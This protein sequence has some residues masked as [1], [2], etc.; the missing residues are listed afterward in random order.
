MLPLKIEH[1]EQFVSNLPIK[2]YGFPLEVLGLDDEFVTSGA[3]DDINDVRQPDWRLAPSKLSYRGTFIL[4][5][6]I[7]VGT[8]WGVRNVLTENLWQYLKLNHKL[9]DGDYYMIANALPTFAQTLN[10]M[11]YAKAIK[12]RKEAQKALMES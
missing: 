4:M 7:G 6:Q 9:N 5:G 8:Q 3:L 12:L 11:S 1:N 2:I 10:V